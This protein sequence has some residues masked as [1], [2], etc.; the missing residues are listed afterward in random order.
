MDHPSMS[1]IDMLGSPAP[2]G[3]GDPVS[4]GAM[5]T[6]LPPSMTGEPVGH[7]TSAAQLSHHSMYSHSPSV[8]SMMSPH[9]SLGHPHH[10]HHPHATPV[11]IPDTDTD[12]R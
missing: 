6:T 8:T 2:H 9:G 3:G 4:S 5:T 10:P 1:S 11:T 12:P 7:P